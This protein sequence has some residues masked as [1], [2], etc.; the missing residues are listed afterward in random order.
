MVKTI[1]THRNT[2]IELDLPVEYV[3]KRVEITCLPLD[4]VNI[5][6]KKRTMSDF[7]GIL[8][9]E[10]A[11]EIHAHINRSRAGCPLVSLKKQSDFYE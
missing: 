3:G 2:H 1:L 5:G 6:E 10:T 4:D 11:K 8:S 7:W 9:D